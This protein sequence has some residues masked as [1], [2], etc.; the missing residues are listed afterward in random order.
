MVKRLWKK[1]ASDPLPLFIAFLVLVISLLNYTPGTFLSGW[2]TLH[3]EFDFGLNFKR[4]IF[5]VWREEQG[6]G[7]VAGHSHMADLPRVFILWLLHFF[8][9]LNTLRYAYIFLCLILGPLGIYCLISHLFSKKKNVHLTAFLS[10]LFY[11]FNL[12][13]V[14]Q[15]YVPFEMFPTQYAFLPW[16]ILFTLKFL[17]KP[18]RK[19]LI[20]FLIFSLFSTPQAYAAHLWYAF[21]GIYVMFLFLNWFLNKK[22][23]NILKNSIFL[24]ALTL[25]V[26]AFWLLPNLYY[27]ATSSEAPR[28][29]KANRLHSQ[30]FLLKNRETGYLKDVALN[31]GFYFNWEIFNFN[32]WKVENLMPKW[33]SHFQNQ[34]IALLGYLFFFLSL[35][36]LIFSFVNK[37]RKVT[38]FVFFFIT[39]FVFLANKTTVFEQIFNILIKNPMF[40]EALRFVFTKFSILFQFGMSIFFAY[41]FCFFTKIFQKHINPVKITVVLSICF[42]IYGYPIFKK[43]LICPKV[44]TKIP[45][46]YFQFWNFMKKQNDGLVLS[47]PLH[48]FSGWQYY[49]WGY[50]GSGFIWFGLKQPV[51]DRDFD[52][53]EVKNEEAFREF[54]YSLYS[55]NPYNFAKTLKKYSANYIVWDKNL[56]TT[57]PKNINQ[58]TFKFETERLINQLEKK[59]IIKEIANFEQLKVY[60][61]NFP[62]RLTSIKNIDHSVFPSYQWHYHDAAY[63]GHLDYFTSNGDN[64]NSYYPFR[65]ILNKYNQLE[66]EIK[67]ENNVWQTE[68]SIPANYQNIITPRPNKIE[69]ELVEK[70]TIEEKKIKFATQT[71]FEFVPPKKNLSFQYTSLN[72]TTGGN[73]YLENLPHSL[74]YIIGIKAKN[75]KNLPLRLCFKNLYTNLCSL[76]EGLKE[77]KD[78]SWNYF[79]VPPTDENFG[80]NLI[81]SNIS[82]GD[83]K[84]INQLEKVVIIPI[85]YNFLNNI[86]LA[87]PEKRR[88][89]NFFI[90][91]QSFN[92]GWLAFYFDGLKPIFLKNHVLINNWANGWEIDQLRIKNEELRIYLVFWPQILEFFGFGLLGIT[93]LRSLKPQKSNK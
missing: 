1:I 7:A 57:V 46:Q 67:K 58:I 8:L 11:L 86:Y 59:K 2:D 17:A 53:W 34:D 9:P 23:K 54:F 29:N 51:L 43:N 84:T 16:I 77:K 10:A 30:E 72:N 3:P 50:Q 25:V 41:W 87:L 90:L 19:N 83:I 48:Q 60:Q 44:K 55:N 31:R 79:L 15:F 42:L 45:H 5:G 21:F 75:L 64:N 82:H 68:F 81:L 6:L 62:S 70:I 26:N 63:S 88:G 69:K 49:D 93:F 22:Q 12:S 20:A 27:I 73:V 40:E 18:N 56:T 36:G 47:L 80:Y 52:R 89:K 85:P 14:Q 71:Y 37:E 61:T 65:K 76:E 13:T 28:L 35:I 92:E 32:N 39:P 33:N 24:I 78:S 91:K 74:G 38:P 4:M 66:I